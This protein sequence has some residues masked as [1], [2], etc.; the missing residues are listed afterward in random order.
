MNRM[1]KTTIIWFVVLLVGGFLLGHVW[2]KQRYS[3]TSAEGFNELQVTYSR[4]MNNFLN[5][6]EERDLIEGAIDGMVKSLG[7]QYSTYHPTEE[8][9][10]YVDSYAG[11]FYGVGAVIKDNNGKF[12]IESVY[13]E[14][15]AEK[16]GLKPNDV[17]LSVNGES[18]T[19]LTLQQLVSKVKGEKDTEVSITVLRGE[20]ELTFTMTRAEIPVY[21]VES[22]MLE[23]NIG[24]INILNFASETDTEFF[25]ALD[26]L[27]AE[28][29]QSLVL[30][31]RS[32]P[33]GL[34]EQARN[35]AD[36]LVPKDE[37]IYEVVFKDEKRHMSYPSRQTEPF[38]K[39]VVVLVNEYSASASE[40]LAAAL[41][42]SAHAEIIGTTTFG[43][44][45][46]QVFNQF[47]S[48]SVLVLTE[49]QWRTPEGSWIN[50]KGVVPTQEVKLPEYAYYEPITSERLL[51][52]DS[53]ESVVQLK[54]WLE[55]IGFKLTSSE[56]YDKETVDAIKSLQ[57][58]YKLEA[59]GA[60]TKELTSY[61][62]NEVSEL[63]KRNDTQLNAAIQEAKN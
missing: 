53:G 13:K 61:I 17:I 26:K 62:Y 52:G 12:T 44:G 55:A 2:T 51:Q 50:G 11:N 47:K 59:T 35:I 57:L 36:V 7:D 4:I 18:S 28:G 46:V 16:S 27:E 25:N 14:M 32:N 24:Y 23:G 56:V 45:I 6:A 31:L 42:E 5:G 30:D 40:L 3:I 48:G 39:K 60:Y 10:E 33:G 58:K 9:Q 20:E 54:K 37:I 34:V 38:N 8:G 29:M 22:E 41:K 49:A 19:G 63:L 43:K 15:P 21:T 1:K